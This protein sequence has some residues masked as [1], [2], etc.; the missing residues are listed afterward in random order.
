MSISSVPIEGRTACG[1]Q[2]KRQQVKMFRVC[3]GITILIIH[4]N[5]HAWCMS[6]KLSQ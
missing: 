3:V 6:V 1:G 5:C 4:L 2:E